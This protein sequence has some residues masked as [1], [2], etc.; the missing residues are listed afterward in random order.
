LD[1]ETV[2][3]RCKRRNS[4][5]SKAG[6]RKSEALTC[7]D[8]TVMPTLAPGKTQQA[9]MWVY[10]GDKHNPYNVFDFTLGRSRD[11]PVRFLRDCKQTLLADPCGGYDGVV[12]GND[13]T[14]VPCAGRTP[15][16]SSSMP[17]RPTRPSP[18]TLGI[19]KRLYAVEDRGKE[20]DVE[21]S[22]ALRQSE[23]VPIDNNV[24]EREMKRVV[25]NP[26]ASG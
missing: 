1:V 7:T 11:G 20:L 26:S 19:I 5:Y 23:S 6:N 16:E 2:P 22:L 17:K 14:Y 25:L 24:G 8:D 12:A 21:T 3:A 10:I 4:I 13:I 15:D 9:R 18:A